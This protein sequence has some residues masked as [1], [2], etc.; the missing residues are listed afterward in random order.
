VALC[1]DGTMAAWGRNYVG[2][3]GDNTTTDRLAPVVVNTTP[4]AP[5]ERFT[6]VGNCSAYHTM[7]LVAAPAA[8]NHPPTVT[9]PAASTIECGSPALVTVLV[10]DLDGDALTV[11]W[12]V[13]GVAA[14][15]NAVPANNPPAPTTTNFSFQA[16]LPLGT[17]SLTVVVADSASNRVSCSTSITVLDTTA[18]V[19]TAAEA[20]PHR[21]W[22]PNHKMVPIT[23]RAEASDTCEEATWKIVG[24]SSNESDARGDGNTAPDWLIT[25]LHTMSLRAERSGQGRGRTYFI[26]IQATD[27]SGNVSAPTIV[28][29][30]VPH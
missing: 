20:E 16:E 27:A 30:D 11:V 10:G 12:A 4:L 2:A 9:C 25:G 6:S 26:S 5:G 8:P 29:V 1:S 13:N 21:L 18:P 24:V 19:I 15:T 17:N 3:L 28:T 7:A 14:Q 23:V 22:P